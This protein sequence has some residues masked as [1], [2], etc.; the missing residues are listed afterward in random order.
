M[1]SSLAEE[2]LDS[3]PFG[4]SVQSIDRVLL[5]EN[6]A[7]REIFG[8]NPREYCFSRWKYLDDQGE[9]PCKFCP[10]RVSLVDGK[11]HSVVANVELQNGK[12][13]F[14]EITHI[15]IINEEGKIEK[16]IEII[17]DVTEKTDELTFLH[18]QIDFKSMIY[19]SIIHFG[20]LGGE[21]LI[22][23]KLPIVND[24]KTFLI[25]EAAY[26]FTAVGQGNYLNEG[27]YGPLPILDKSDYVS[28]GFSRVMLS[29]NSDSRLGGKDY[30][31]I[32]IFLPRFLLPYFNNRERVLSF[33]KLQLGLYTYSEDLIAMDIDELKKD[34]I[35]F[36]FQKVAAD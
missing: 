18:S 32:L 19:L 3:L 25:N 33:F 17:K 22:T 28:L 35:E 7:M 10:G 29:N 31:F 2:I 16:F 14:L 20:N 6:K 12:K 21:I 13:A 30:V 11:Q 23:E 15:P 26:W 5:Y 8:D 4:I 24:L 1:P 27:L 9:A 34:F 36:L